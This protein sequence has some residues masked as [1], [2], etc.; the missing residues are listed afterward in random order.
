MLVV[1]DIDGHCQIFDVTTDAQLHRWLSEMLREFLDAGLVTDLDEAYRLL[2]KGTG[3]ELLEFMDG[4]DSQEDDL[5]KSE[6]TGG[7][8]WYIRSTE[9]EWRRRMFF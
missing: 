3:A 9:S 8:R 5:P 4:E 7:C 6:R 2:E 1:N